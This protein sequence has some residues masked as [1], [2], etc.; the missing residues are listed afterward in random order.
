MLPPPHAPAKPFTPDQPP[1]MQKKARSNKSRRGCL[2]AA[3]KL[4]P[5]KP[6]HRTDDN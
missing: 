4:R 6:S 3:K 1:G 2:P 5:G